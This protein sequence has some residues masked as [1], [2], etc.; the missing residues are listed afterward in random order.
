MSNNFGYV[1]KKTKKTHGHRAL[2]SLVN[3]LASDRRN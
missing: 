3:D 1:F 2:S